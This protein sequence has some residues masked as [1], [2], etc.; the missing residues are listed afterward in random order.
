MMSLLYAKRAM[1]FG[2]V[3]LPRMSWRFL[4]AASRCR[5]DAH[6]GIAAG[7]VGLNPSAERRHE[8]SQPDC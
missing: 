1:C 8:R 3:V 6:P 4:I 5:T 7:R 2:R